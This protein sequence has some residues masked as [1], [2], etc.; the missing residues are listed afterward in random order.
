MAIQGH[1]L[2]G[3]VMK[4]ENLMKGDKY[5]V[6]TND[7]MRSGMF[8]VLHGGSKGG[9]SGAL[10][11]IKRIEAQF[12]WPSPKQDVIT[13]VKECETCQR[14]KSEHLPTPGLL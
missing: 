12:Y 10:A 2:D 3:F 5:Y 4:D 6:G 7:E 8:Q 1:L 13:W 14:N 9:H 11:T